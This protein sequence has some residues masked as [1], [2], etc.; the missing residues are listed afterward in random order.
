LKGFRY[1]E[2]AEILDM[3]L[4]SVM[5]RIFRGRRNMRKLLMNFAIEHG[6]IRDEGKV[7]V[8]A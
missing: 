5:S 7:E 6:Y 4:G 3:P 2:V 1:R 8:A